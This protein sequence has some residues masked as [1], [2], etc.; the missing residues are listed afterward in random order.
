MLALALTHALV[1]STPAKALFV[2]TRCGSLLCCAAL[3]CCIVACCCLF[4][5]GGYFGLLAIFCCLWAPHFLIILYLL[6]VAKTLSRFQCSVQCRSRS[7]SLP[8]PYSLSKFRPHGPPSPPTPSTQPHAPD[9]PWL[10][11]PAPTSP[12]SFPVSRFLYFSPAGAAIRS[13]ISSSTTR[14]CLPAARPSG[15][16]PPT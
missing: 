2:T 6:V 10:L 7:A 4:L 13:E 15:N 5:F 11:F 8:G 9:R 12:I 3:A 1:P 16:P 14:R